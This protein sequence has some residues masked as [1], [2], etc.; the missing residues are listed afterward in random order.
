MADPLAL[1]ASV[2]AVIQIS[3]RIIGLTKH[4]IEA[5]QDA[6]RD[7][8]VI[9]IEASTLKAIFESMKLLLDSGYSFSSSLRKLSEKDGAIEGCRRSVSELESLLEPLPH[10]TSDGKRRKVQATLSSLAWPLKESKAI[11]LLDEILQ[12]KKTIALSLSTEQ[13]YVICSILF[14]S[15]CHA[16]LINFSLPGDVIDAS[17][18][19]TMSKRWASTKSPQN[20]R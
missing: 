3:D 10:P 9:R 7:L 17:I 1:G 13:T 16:C 5:A 6:P 11:K 12:Y 4:Y 19:D 20:S 15:L 2:I 8:H 14:L 18:A